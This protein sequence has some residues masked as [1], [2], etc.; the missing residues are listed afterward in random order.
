[1]ILLAKGYYDKNIL[2]FVVKKNTKFKKN[3]LL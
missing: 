1:M 2:T 3:Q